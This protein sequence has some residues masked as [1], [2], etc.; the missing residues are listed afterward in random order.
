MKL[1]AGYAA[2]VVAVTSMVVSAA[3]VFMDSSEK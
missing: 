3:M 1:L 2:V